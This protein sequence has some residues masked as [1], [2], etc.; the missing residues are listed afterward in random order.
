MRVPALYQISLLLA[1]AAA[2]EAQEGQLTFVKGAW[3]RVQQGGAEPTPN[4]RISSQVRVL[5]KGDSKSS[6]PS[7][8]HQ[9]ARSN[10]D[11][12]Q[13]RRLV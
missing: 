8:H 11:R 1:I 10:R 3:E 12:G 6:R 9:F 13:G 5:L 7:Y 4:L 2:L